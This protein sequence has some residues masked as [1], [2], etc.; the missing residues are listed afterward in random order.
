MK[1]V[2]WK[3]G[4]NVSSLTRD[5]AESTLYAQGISKP[6]NELGRRVECGMGDTT[7]GAP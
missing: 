6:G 3:R 5:A 2:I 1:W 4:G 7:K